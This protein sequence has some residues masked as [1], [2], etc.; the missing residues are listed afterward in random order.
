MATSLAVGGALAMDISVD[1]RRLMGERKVWKAAESTW[2]CS[3]WILRA[4]S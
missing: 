1:G 3:L 4:K 2:I